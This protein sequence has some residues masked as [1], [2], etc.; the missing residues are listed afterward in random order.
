[1]TTDAA[2]LGL[3]G[4]TEKH[5]PAPWT[6]GYGGVTINCACGWQGEG[7]L[8]YSEHVAAEVR[9]WYRAALTSPEVE[10]AGWRALL[11]ANNGPFSAQAY[12]HT[13][14]AAAAETLGA[15]P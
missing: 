3:T 9:T 15:T 11:A 1:M 7:G 2:G 4:V 8:G 13:V 6:Y 10:E 5:R 12:A 14:L